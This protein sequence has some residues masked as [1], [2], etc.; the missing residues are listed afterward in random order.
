MKSR[1]L[2]LFFVVCSL[3]LQLF[4]RTITDMSQ[5]NV[6]VP[7]NIERVFG[8]APPTTFLVALYN[9]KLLAGLN[10]PAYNQNNYGSEKYLGEHFMNLPI[11]GGWHG[12]QK[13]AS[14][15][16]LL[17]VNAQIILAWQNDFL[18]K[19]V[20]SSLQKVNI[21]IVMIEADVLE[22]TPQTFRFLGKLFNMT[23]RG[24]ALASYA[25]KTLHEIAQM[26]H[27][28]PK[29]QQVSFYYAQGANGLQSDCSNSFHTTQ[30]RYINA[31]NIYECTQKNIMGMESLNFESI[32][33]ANPD[34][35]IV[36]SAKFYKDIFLNAQ[37][38]MLDAVKNKRV[39]LV[40]KTPFNWIDRPPSFMRLLGIHWLSSVMYPQYYTKDIKQEIQKF[41]ELFF[42]IK[43]THDEL[44]EITKGAF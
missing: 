27:K 5:T 10:F 34:F 11:L 36:Q 19:Q 3:T 4:A 13:G 2:F 26:T 28:I 35:I 33:K 29:E 44:T 12:N 8:S 30:F 42:H 15:E 25:E 14:I 17:S 31:N 1:F 38:K 32:F 37:W 22:K 43:L 21:P 23:Q 39:Y 24:E 18:L 6:E 7:Q 40:P 16:K 41:Y 9:P 20:Q